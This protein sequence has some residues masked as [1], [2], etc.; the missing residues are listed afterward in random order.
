ML[1]VVCYQQWVCVST[2]ARIV[3]VRSKWMGYAKTIK[4]AD[5]PSVT[6]DPEEGL[7]EVQ[8]G[9]EVSIG[10]KAS[11]VPHPIVTWSNEV[12]YLIQQF[13]ITSPYKRNKTEYS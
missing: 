8:L 11:G 6:P 13:K 7:L 2:R 5:P 10:C 3:T 9:E 12:Q 1:W 4:F